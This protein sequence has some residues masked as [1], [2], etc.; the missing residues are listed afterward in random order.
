MAVYLCLLKSYNFCL[1]YTYM[2]SL[3]RYTVYDVNI[4]CINLYACT[5][6]YIVHVDVVIDYYSSWIIIFINI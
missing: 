5:W 3:A 1:I 2:Y 4:Y 6:S